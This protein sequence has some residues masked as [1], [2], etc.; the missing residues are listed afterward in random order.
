MFPASAA[1]GQ[2]VLAGIVREDSTGRPMSGVEVL[3][4]GTKRQT[5]TDASGRYLLI[6]LPTGVRVALF[7]S[8]GYRP[9][10]QRIR[11]VVEDTVL[12]DARLV[13]EGTVLPP[14]E[15]TGRTPP[16]AGLR[17][18]FEERRASGFGKFID[19]TEL[20]RNEHMRL[21]DLMRRHGIEIVR[22]R[23][24][25]VAPMFRLIPVVANRAK[26]N[27]LMKVILNGMAV[28][29]PDRDAGWPTSIDEFTVGS[30]EAVEVYQNVAQVP[31]EFSD[32][33]ACG[34]VVL[35]SRQR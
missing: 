7:R 31:V 9:V 22:I 6:D 8:I 13:A 12:A 32:A 18:G 30:L 21:G 1:S 19:S 17:G 15:V 2:A 27:C 10:R 16:P 3:V 20:R 23:D 14:L 34:V 25:R 35:W 5:L 29:D 11:L 33:I 28:Y 24:T 26:D 4:E